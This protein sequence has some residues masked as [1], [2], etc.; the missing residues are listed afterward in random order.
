MLTL[1]SV[2]RSINEI[3]DELIIYVPQAG[4]LSL[5]SNVELLSLASVE[6]VD[7]NLRYLLEVQLA[8]DVIETWS[9][10][11]NGTVPTVEEMFA[12]ISYYAEW[13]SYIPVE[14]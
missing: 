5:T 6:N 10:W 3:D 11:R 12:A 13:D 9:E 2:L 1:E 8:K 7:P 14:S 4:H